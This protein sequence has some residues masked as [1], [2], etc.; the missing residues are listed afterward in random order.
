[1]TK[2]TLNELGF[3]TH[4]EK[5]RQENELGE[6]PPGRVTAV[7]RERYSVWTEETELEAELIGHLRFASESPS[8]LPAVGDWVVVDVFDGHRG[9]IHGVYPR[10][11]S[12]ERQ[13]VGKF[14]E[15]QI[16]AAN[17]DTALI[18]LAADR[19]FS[20]N[21]I[22][23][24]LAVCHSAEIFP[25][26]LLSKTDL[27][28]HD[29]TMQ[30]TDMIGSRIPGI[31][32][33]PMSNE[34]CLGLDRIREYLAPGKTCCLLG[35]SGVGKSTLLNRLAGR[36][37]MET[38]S[39]SVSS[40]RGR[41]KTTRRELIMLSEGGMIIDNPGMREVGLADAEKGLSVTFD[42][43]MQLAENCRFSDCTHQNEAGCAVLAAV[44]SG[45]LDSALYA[46]Y[47]KLRKEQAHFESTVSERRRKDRQF[48]K[49]VKQIKK[50]KIFKR[51]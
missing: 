20:I 50:E 51:M 16:I 34:T 40:D 30:L 35:S 38:A 10:K 17:I 25:V 46:H 26:I 29:E 39:I 18:V 44:E 31:P 28:D 9:L 15:T 24:Y 27:L 33:I 37:V 1:M 13:A 36:P 42:P 8:D 6:M 48:G 41:H 2:Y 23:R 45:E 32:C 4:Q 3:G 49:M 11:N 19:D 43:V 12:L 7:H 14:G 21:R 5:F 47:V 22:E